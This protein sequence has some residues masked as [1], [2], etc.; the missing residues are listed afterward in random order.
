MLNRKKMNKIVTH[1]FLCERGAKWL[2][3][4]RHW[5]FRCQ[6]V[7]I[8]FVSAC[9]ENPDIF[10]I[11]GGKNICIEVKVSRA[12]FKRDIKKPHR[13]T[14]GIG[15][16][17]YYMCPKGMIEPEEIENGWGLIEYDPETNSFNCTKNSDYFNIRDYESE[18]NLLYSLI[19]RLA[20]KSRVL[21]FRT[22]N[23]LN[24]TP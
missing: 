10:G 8:E 6:Y 5:N 21:D 20:G 2:N 3:T 11:R 1:R 14:A 22:I 16:T 18:Q 17:R 12:D 13:Q 15:A 19:R 4:I 24:P 23:N 7:L 9:R